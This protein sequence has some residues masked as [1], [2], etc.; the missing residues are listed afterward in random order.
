MY[1]RKSKNIIIII[2]FFVTQIENKEHHQ[3][4]KVINGCMYG[5]VYLVTS[6]IALYI[7]MTIII[8]AIICRA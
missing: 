3:E 8:I 7:I 2:F 5:I 6:S 4:I 1:N